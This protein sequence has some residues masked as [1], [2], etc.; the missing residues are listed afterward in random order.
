M[1]VTIR[2]MGV[3]AANAIQGATSDGFSPIMTKLS[4]A[5]PLKTAASAQS[6]SPRT[7]FASAA[8]HG[9]SMPA[10]ATMPIWITVCAMPAC[11]HG[12]MTLLKGS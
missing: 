1:A 7:G 12:P 10:T 11:S 6:T 3:A 2:M 9:S 5:S 4:S 8:R